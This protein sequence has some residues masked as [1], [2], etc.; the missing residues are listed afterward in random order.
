MLGGNE[1]EGCLIDLADVTSNKMATRSSA[2]VKSN[3]NSN[4]SNEN[5]D[6][7][8]QHPPVP[9]KGVKGDG[10]S[11]SITPKAPTGDA[12]AFIEDLLGETKQQLSPAH[13]AVSSDSEDK[14]QNMT[15]ASPP[16]SP[17]Y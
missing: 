13:R 8:L 16:A 6:V 9:N 14:M 12:F 10:P 3:I 5:I 7:M 11:L 17:V 1:T 15:P 4:D 2:T